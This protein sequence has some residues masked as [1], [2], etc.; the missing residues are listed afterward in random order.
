MSLVTFAD[1]QSAAAHIAPVA[2]RTPVIT[3]HTLDERVGANVFLK[4]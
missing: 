3:S 4:C 2:H 1:V